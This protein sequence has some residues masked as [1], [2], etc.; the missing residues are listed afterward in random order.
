M[1]AAVLIHATRVAVT[2]RSVSPGLFEM[3][4]LAGRQRVL[5]RLGKTPAL[6]RPGADIL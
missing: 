5:E 6:T 4:E 2:G 1:K 3:L